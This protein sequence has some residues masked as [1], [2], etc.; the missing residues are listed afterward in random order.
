MK[1]I[2]LTLESLAYDST[3]TRKFARASESHFTVYFGTSTLQ[4]LHVLIEALRWFCQAVRPYPCGQT[5]RMFVSG[6]RESIQSHSRNIYGYTIKPLEVLNKK[7]L[8]ESACWVEIFDRAIIAELK[9][10]DSWGRGLELS[11]EMMTQLSGVQNLIWIEDKTHTPSVGK[12]GGY[13]LIGFFTALVPIAQDAAGIQ[14]HLE[15]S[16]ERLLSIANLDIDINAKEWLKVRDVRELSKSRC[17][18]GWCETANVLLGTSALP[19]TMKWTG[20]PQ[21][22]RTLHTQGYGATGQ[23]GANPGPIQIVGQVSGNWHFVSNRQRFDPAGTYAKAIQIASKQVAL[24]YDASSKRGWL[25]PQLSLMLHLCHTYYRYFAKQASGHEYPVPFAQLSTDGSDAA[26]AAL[27]NQGDVV[28]FTYGDESED[29]IKLRNVLVDINAKLADTSGTRECPRG[30]K[31]FGTELMDIIAEP[32]RGG[33]LT[34]IPTNHS[35]GTWSVLTKLV[36]CIC[37]CADLGLAIQP[38]SIPQNS[39]CQCMILQSE[40]HYLAA[41]LRC[42]DLLLERHQRSLDEL[43]SS[44]IKISDH[45]NWSF[46]PYTSCRHENTEPFW[47]KPDTFLQELTRTGFVRSQKSPSKMKSPPPL[48]G[49]VIFGKSDKSR[50][51]AWR[52]LALLIY[53]RLSKSRNTASNPD[54]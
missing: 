16:G 51:A 53:R 12:E 42:L 19:N 54:Q 32:G 35:I 45:G 39:N 26:H 31:V 34:E 50:L 33:L 48:T 47:G 22:S 28:L 38:A 37:F 11:F 5:E 2:S 30:P 43:R 14:W 20:L 1:T 23:V 13:I 40:R 36:D 27:L 15:Y 4:E 10:P 46:N 41:H 29:K 49:A 21:R 6:I 24:V 25:V 8:G 52:K 3:A 17:F 7:M 9:L 44:I 18:L